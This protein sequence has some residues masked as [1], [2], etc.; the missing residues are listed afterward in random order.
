MP[1]TT[2]SSMAVAKHPAASDFMFPPAMSTLKR[3]GKF[4]GA[5]RRSLSESF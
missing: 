3:E 5:K 4:M 1:P 2:I